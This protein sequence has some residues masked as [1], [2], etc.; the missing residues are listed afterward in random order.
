M[1]LLAPILSFTAEE[2]WK[3]LR[4]QE[5]PLT[6]FTDTYH[7]YPEIADSDALV[8]KWN[9]IRDIRAEAMRRIEEVRATGKV[10]SSLAAEIDIHTGGADLEILRSLGDDLRF[11]LIVSRATVHAGGGDALRI[12]VNA[13]E[14]Q[15]CERC[16]HH[17]DDVGAN[18]A[19]PT[20]CGRCSDNLF[21]DGEVREHA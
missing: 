1:K 19:H 6:I 21:G 12:E 15:K 7:R 4:A 2:A 13:T 9:R 8:A 20:I 3:Y 5:E 10:G 18:E 14:A 16:W 11:V 17:R